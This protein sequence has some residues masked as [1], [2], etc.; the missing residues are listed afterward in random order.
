MRVADH[1]VGDA[2]VTRRNGDSFATER[3]GEAKR[4]G[5][6]VA[7]LFGKLQAAPPLDVERDP[8]AV[9]AVG[10]ALGVADEAG[11]AR[12]LADADENALA[13]RPR[14]LDRMR[15]HFREQLLVNALGGAA[16]CQFAQCG[17]V[18]R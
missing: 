13:R 11:G 16:Q 3:L 2:S 10:Q 8:G 18:G 12:I 4:V 5:N 14:A 17:E 1:I 15:L 9:Q 7:I 6:P